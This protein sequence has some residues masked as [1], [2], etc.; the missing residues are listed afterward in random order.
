MRAAPLALSLAI[1]AAPAFADPEVSGY[2]LAPY[3]GAPSGAAYLTITNPDAAE[4]TLDSVETPAAGM[5]M[6]HETVET[7][8]VM[9]MAP[10]DGPLTIAPGET[11]AMEPGG[12][13]V[14]LGGLG[15][16]LA[17]GDEIPL[18]LHFAGGEE[19]TATLTLGQP[20]D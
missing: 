14:M 8:G 1:L 2:V 5:A 15:A 4:I 10:P 9:S 17:E 19:V 16:E 3:P 13:H 20:S 6:L 18:T 7:D 12:L 11:L